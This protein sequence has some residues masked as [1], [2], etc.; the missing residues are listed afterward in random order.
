[1]EHPLV[2]YTWF[3]SFPSFCGTAY[4]Q[5]RTRKEI[6]F[7]SQIAVLF[8]QLY[9]LNYKSERETFAICEKF[10]ENT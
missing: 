2:F 10:G 9:P 7:V 5:Q 4:S 8:P 3:L 6:L 1:M